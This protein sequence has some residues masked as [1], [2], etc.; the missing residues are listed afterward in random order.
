MNNSGSAKTSILWLVCGPGFSSLIGSFKRAGN[1][2]CEII[3]K[4][5]TSNEIKGKHKSLFFISLL[6]KVKIYF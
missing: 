5:V 2:C 1:L 4:L 3:A 6:L